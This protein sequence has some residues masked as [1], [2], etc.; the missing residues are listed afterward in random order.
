M[1]MVFMVLFLKYCLYTWFHKFKKKEEE[2]T[3]IKMQ[4][5]L[6]YLKNV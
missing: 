6:L 4:F 1:Y 3:F 2:N 5:L